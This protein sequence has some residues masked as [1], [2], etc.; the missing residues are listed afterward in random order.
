MDDTPQFVHDCK[1]CVFLG[2][3]NAV[4]E[5]TYNHVDYDLYFCKKG[6]HTTVIARYG[7]KE[8][9]YSSGIMFHTDELTEA[10]RRAKEKGLI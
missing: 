3:F 6:N 4:D 7:D 8:W 5:N 9:E 2:R 10:K 1:E